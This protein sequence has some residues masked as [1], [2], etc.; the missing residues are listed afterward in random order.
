[1]KLLISLT[2]TA[3][4]AACGPGQASTAAGGPAETRE[5]NG[6]DQAPAFAGQTRAPDVKAGVA[7]AVSDHVTGL[8]KPWGLAFLP[9]GGL[10]ITENCLLYTS[11]SPRDS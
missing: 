9:D 2:A 7:Y 3:L 4:L 11:P 5:P 6:K 1:M 10:L 8:Q